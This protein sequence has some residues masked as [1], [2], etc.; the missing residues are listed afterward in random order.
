MSSEAPGVP[1]EL[2]NELNFSFNGVSE[3]VAYVSVTPGPVTA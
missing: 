1:G 2:T 3:V